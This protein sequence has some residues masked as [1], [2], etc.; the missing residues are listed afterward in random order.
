MSQSPPSGPGRFVQ[1][2]PV[3]TMQT[4]I[5]SSSISPYMWIVTGPTSKKP[6]SGEGI[7]ASTPRHSAEARDVGVP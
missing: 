4:A 2:S 5:A 1:R 3:T 6:L 7:D